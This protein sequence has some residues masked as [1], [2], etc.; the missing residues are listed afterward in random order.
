MQSYSINSDRI[1][2]ISSLWA[3][4]IFTV[5]FQSAV[6]AKPTPIF[7]CSRDTRTRV[8]STII[9]HDTGRTHE[10]I[11][12]KSKFILNP[13]VTCRNAVDRFQTLFDRGDLDFIKIGHSRKTQG[14]IICGLSAKNKHD[15]CNENNKLFDL[16]PRITPRTALNGLLQNMVSGSNP[17]IYQGSDDEI[18]V[19]FKVSIEQS[20]A[21]R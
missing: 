14:T 21:K 6:E 11:Q 3:I 19:N 5:I 13:K 4:S 12:W 1:L 9:K 16:S 10:I 20:Q 17:P 18:V 15:S 7:E 2:I 8:Y